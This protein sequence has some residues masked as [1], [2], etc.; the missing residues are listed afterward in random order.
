[1]PLLSKSAR[2]RHWALSRSHMVSL[3]GDHYTLAMSQG[4]E[5]R[6]TTIVAND[7]VGYLRLIRADEDGAITTLPALRDRS[8]IRNLLNTMAQLSR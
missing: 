8:L 7:I 3:D 1:M 2:S 5:R 6:L 4:T